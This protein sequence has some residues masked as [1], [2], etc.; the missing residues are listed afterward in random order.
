MRWLS[1]LRVY[2]FLASGILVM[3]VS[4]AIPLTYANSIL[5]S[6]D[7]AMEEACAANP[8]DCKSNGMISGY[9]L[10]QFLYKFFSKGRVIF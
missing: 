5:P 4:V 10:D 1:M 2:H 8:Y 9:T 6:F 7:K 3:F